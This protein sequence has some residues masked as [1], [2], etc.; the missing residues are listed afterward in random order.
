MQE[1][2][3]VRRH[4]MATRR[5]Q[6]RDVD[7]ASFFDVSS[8]DLEASTESYDE[9]VLFESYDDSTASDDLIR[10]DERVEQEAETPEEGAPV[11]QE[12]AQVEEESRQQAPSQSLVRVRCDG[13]LFARRK[14]CETRQYFYCTMK[15]C[16]AG[17]VFDTISGLS[18]R[19]KN[20]HNHPLGTQ[21]NIAETNAEEIAFRQFVR[22]NIHL[23]SSAIYSM[24][25]RRDPQEGPF[26]SL[27]SI[28]VKRIDNVKGQI[29]GTPAKQ[30]LNSLL[31]AP[32]TEIDGENFLALQTVKPH[33]IMFATKASLEKLC[34]ASQ[35]VVLKV[36]VKGQNLT[37]GFC[38]YALER[39]RILPTVWML[40]DDGSGSLPWC[41]LKWLLSHAASGSSLSRLWVIPAAPKYLEWLSHTVR[42]NDHI[43]ALGASYVLQVEKRAQDLDEGHREEILSAFRLIANVPMHAVHTQI[44][45]IEETW[46]TRDVQAFLA[47]WRSR[48]EMRALLYHS[49]LV[50]SDPSVEACY[51]SNKTR[52]L[53]HTTDEELIA[54]VHQQY[55]EAYST[56]E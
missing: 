42:A 7:R 1:E 33:V 38:V 6:L 4:R 45:H 18:K 21:D 43:R 55:R 34:M 22:E 8:S 46:Q 56:T 27:E 11:H 47:W 40:F 49:S 12:A 26:P 20:E 29:G 48:F 19:N 16:K 32:M 44:R 28:N 3:D 25:L 39:G 9:N 13:C 17:F 31:P 37:N 51:Q 53:I 54:F 10:D 36:K 14:V 23:D 35:C 5:Q 15:G 50:C 24:I 41:H 2:D 30:I 52:E